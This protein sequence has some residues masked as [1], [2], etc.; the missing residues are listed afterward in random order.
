MVSKD[1]SEKMGEEKHCFVKE[2]R[3]YISENK[4]AKTQTM[5][6]LKSFQPVPPFRSGP[7]PGNLQ[8]SSGGRVNS[9]I[10]G[11]STKKGRGIFT[12]ENVLKRQM[13]PNVPKMYPYG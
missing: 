12:K 2:C 10:M 3:S 5:V 6:I 13:Y 8:R 7:S 1:Q 4:R 11:R 9:W